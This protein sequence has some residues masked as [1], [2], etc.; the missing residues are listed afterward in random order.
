MIIDI[1][2]IIIMN[3]SL[4]VILN[5]I[6]VVLIPVGIILLSVKPFIEHRVQN[7]L[8]LDQKFSNCL[9]YLL[10]DIIEKCFNCGIIISIIGIIFIFLS[11]I[12][13]FEKTIEDK[14]N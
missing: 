14:K 2:L 5:S 13:F 12:H 8:M 1:I 3:K 10:N 11:S 6:G 4:R 7:I 9:V